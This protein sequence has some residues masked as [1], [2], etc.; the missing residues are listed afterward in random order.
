MG[1]GISYFGDLLIFYAKA[2]TGSIKFICLKI[3][4]HIITAT[5]ELVFD[6]LE[7]P[8]GDTPKMMLLAL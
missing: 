6:T 1:N 8:Y 3:V 2:S 5:W 7:S 4:I